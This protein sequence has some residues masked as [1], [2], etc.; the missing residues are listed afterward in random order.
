[1]KNKVDLLNGPIDSSLRV[2]TFPLAISFV[3]HMLYAWVDTFYVSRLGSTSIAAIGISEQLIFFIFTLGGGFSIGSGI[4]VARRIGEGNQEK[5]DRTATQAISLMF[6]YSSALAVFL[7]FMTEPVLSAMNV[8]GELAE[9]SSQYL[10]AVV[11]GVPGNYLVFQINA[12]VR[13][14]GN[15]IFPMIMLITGTVLNA[16]LSPLLVF[17]LGPFPRLEI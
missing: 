1:M 17:G 9:L 16:I 11:L 4:V 2:F 12:I 8:E 5:A 7:F 14:S 15:S 10:Y 13:S 6:I 3:I